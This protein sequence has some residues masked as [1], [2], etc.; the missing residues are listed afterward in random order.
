LGVVYNPTAL[1]RLG[2]RD[3][4]VVSEGLK[5]L[6]E[7]V[8]NGSTRYNLEVVDKAKSE[9]GTVFHDLSDA[10]HIQWQLAGKRAASDFERQGD[11]DPLIKA[12]M[13]IVRKFNP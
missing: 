5:K 13:Q 9:F 1:Q 6:A 7:H 2:E 8:Y 12:G 4:A 3:Q 10:E 11:N